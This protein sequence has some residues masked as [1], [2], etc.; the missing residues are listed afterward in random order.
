MDN[1]QEEIFQ[2]ATLIVVVATAL[3]CMC[4]FLIFLNP[5]I[6]LNPFK[7]PRATPTLVAGLP[8]T[9]TPTITG[10]PTSTPTVTFTPIPTDTPL[11]TTTFTPTKR[12]TATRRPAT[13]VPLPQPTPIRIVNQY[14]YRPVLQKC[15]HSGGT[16]VKGTVWIG[17]QPQFDVHVRI[18]WTPNGSSVASDAITGSRADGSTS[19]T[20]V[21]KENGSFGPTPATWFVWIID[22]NGNPVSD[23]SAGRIVTNNLPAENGGSCWL[24]VM[25]FVHN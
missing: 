7:P 9:W 14:P 11:P 19:Y 18:S 25:D 23:P 22:N 10:T 2:I 24:A 13:A 6:A 16:F 15:E 20:F 3:V 5:Q 21:L 17:S 4:Y 8:A 12:P 1:E